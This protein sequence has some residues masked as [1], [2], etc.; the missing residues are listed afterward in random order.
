MKQNLQKFTILENKIIFEAAKK[1]N[2]NGKRFLAIVNK[3]KQFLGT[4]T[5]SD[6]R[7][8]LIDGFKKESLISNIY[9]KKAKFIIHNKNFKTDYFIKFFKHNKSI[10]AIPIIKKN[11]KILNIV[12][13]D[14]IYVKNENLDCLILAG[15]Y[16][17]RLQ[18]ITKFTAKPLI[19]FNNKPYICNLIEKIKESQI[20]KIYISVFFKS[21]QIKSIVKKFFKNDVLN[22]KIIFVEELKPLG[23][24]GSLKKIKKP[25]KQILVLNSDIIFNVNIDNF[26]DLHNKNKNFVTIVTT[27]YNIK[28]PYGVLVNKGGLLKKIIEKPSYKFFINCGIYI[29]NSNISKLIKQNESINMDNLLERTIRKQKK[30]GLYPLTENIIDYGTHQSLQYAQENFEK[31]FNY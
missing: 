5:D 28:I 29:L 6:I 3:N 26:L 4:L 16:G 27:D 18:P 23:T 2:I 7:R 10:D 25:S 24:I 30:I 20:D 8:G 31:I 14:E 12:F 21:F 1:I 22:K 19:H 17:K 15:G 13:K 9:N 11:K